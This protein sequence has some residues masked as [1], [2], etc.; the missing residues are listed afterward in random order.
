MLLLVPMSG[1]SIHENILGRLWEFQGFR[2]V[3][4]EWSSYTSPSMGWGTGDAPRPCISSQ[5]QRE[6][7]LTPGRS[8]RG[9]DSAPWSLAWQQR[10]P[11]LPGLWPSPL[12]AHDVRPR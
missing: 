10:D 4:H 3:L 11:P 7:A 12:R 8:R 9:A 5:S 1:A 6:H 2:L